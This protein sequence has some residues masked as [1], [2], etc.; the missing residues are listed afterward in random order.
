MKSIR[1]DLVKIRTLIEAIKEA[2]MAG[3]VNPV[4]ADWVLK[5]LKEQLVDPGSGQLL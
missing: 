2:K 5:E 4:L 1:R 3:Y